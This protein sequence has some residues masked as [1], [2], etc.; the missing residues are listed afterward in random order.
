[1]AEALYYT[2]KQGQVECQLCPHFC[3]LREGET[4]RCQ[5]RQVTAG[6]LR[7]TTYN[8]VSSLALDPIE[9]KPLYHFQPGSQILSLGTVGCNLECKFCQNYQLAHNL[10]APTKEITPQQA[11]DIACQ[12]DCIGLAYTYSEPA[13][14]YEYILETAQLA[15]Q[16]GLKNVLVTN[17]MINPEPLE[18]LVPYIDAMNLDIK[19]FQEEFYQEIC[20][21]SLAPVKRTAQLVQQEL[22]LELTT[23]VIP[24]LNDS[25]AEIKEL[26]SW[27]K[28]LGVEIPLHLSRYFPRY[29]LN[30]NPTPVATMLQAAEIASE[31]LNHVYLGNLEQ[32][33]YQTTYCPSCQQP[34]IKRDHQVEINL[35]EGVC[36]KCHQ[37][38]N[39]IL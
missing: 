19:A 24:G 16:A 23:L 10:E 20:Q 32:P 26:V 35:P 9:K 39:L 36:P 17:G 22:L 25:P 37:E 6:Q 1:M 27:I 3:Q 13:V 11:V 21:G 2:T 30:K 5:V 34:V 38:L 31:H 8:Q 18:E 7:A 12:E 14:W 28:Q 15:Q 33:K 29:Q 4:G